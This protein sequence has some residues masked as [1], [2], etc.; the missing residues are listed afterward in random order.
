MT[1]AREPG[2]ERLGPGPMF[3]ALATL[4]NGKAQLRWSRAQIF[5]LINTSGFALLPFFYREG[6]IAAGWRLP[7]VIALA[8]GGLMLSIVWLE[9]TK[10]ANDWMDFWNAKMQNLE[11]EFGPDEVSVFGSEEFKTTNIKTPTFHATLVIL[12]WIFIILWG[13]LL[14]IAIN[15]AVTGVGGIR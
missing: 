9:V 5:L 2:P 15:L 10:R 7:L 13:L 1:V 8:I 14:L 11:E 3:I 12:A 4:R 6:V